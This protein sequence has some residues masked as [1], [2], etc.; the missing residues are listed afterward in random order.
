[1]QFDSEKMICARVKINV[2]GNA[3]ETAQLLVKHF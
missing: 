1:M 3:Y 2:E